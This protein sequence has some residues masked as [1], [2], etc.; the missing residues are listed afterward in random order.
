MSYANII[1]S[2]FDFL[3]LQIVLQEAEIMNQGKT[4]FAQIMSLI[5]RYEFDKCVKRYNGNRH[6]IGFK[7][8]D[9]FLVMS[10]VFVF[11]LRIM[12]PPLDLDLAW[13]YGEAF[14]HLGHVA[15]LDRHN[16]C[17]HKRCYMSEGRSV[18][19][20]NIFYSDRFATMGRFHPVFFPYSYRT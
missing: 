11:L 16:L 6:A 9:Q 13:N 15:R 2:R 7:C 10:S 8:R 20:R 5:P 14:P 3:L 12:R 18:D 1:F 19:T 4:V 17:L